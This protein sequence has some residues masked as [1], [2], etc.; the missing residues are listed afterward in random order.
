MNY[1]ADAP[2]NI[3]IREARSRFRYL[4]Q[5]EPSVNDIISHL[6]QKTFFP[7]WINDLYD[8]GSRYNIALDYW[9]YGWVIFDNLKPCIYN[10]DHIFIHMNHSSISIGFAVAATEI[11]ITSHITLLAR[12]LHPGELLGHS[13]L[14]A[15]I[16]DPG[17][18]VSASLKEAQSINALQNPGPSRFDLIK[19][20]P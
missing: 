9:L 14:E 20:D 3:S 12:R 18:S 2:L 19:G 1:C 4:Y 13:F 11:D 10:P 17:L 16:F 8:Q 6:V 7:D 5:T 15:L